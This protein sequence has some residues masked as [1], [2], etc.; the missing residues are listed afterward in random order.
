MSTKTARRN[1]GLV[2]LAAV[3]LLAALVGA[4]SSIAMCRV[5]CSASLA[6]PLTPEW[7]HSLLLAAVIDAVTRPAPLLVVLIAALLPILPE[8]GKRGKALRESLRLLAAVYGSVAIGFAMYAIP[9]LLDT[10]FFASNYSVF[11]L[12]YSTAMLAATLLGVTMAVKIIREKTSGHRHAWTK[13][14][15]TALA[16][17]FMALTL[18]LVTEAVLQPVSRSLYHCSCNIP[19]SSFIPIAVSERIHMLDISTASFAASW[20]YALTLIGLLVLEEER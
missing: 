2:V 1:P 12:T 6:E 4:A 3:A 17:L 16:I 18:R 9:L 11:S 14:F 8:G 19:R 20:V 15:V 13:A 10:E 7:R 5:A